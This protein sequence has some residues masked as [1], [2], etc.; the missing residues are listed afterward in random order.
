MKCRTALRVRSVVE[1]GL[2]TW[3]NPD[4]RAW[5][6]IRCTDDRVPGRDGASTVAASSY[7]SRPYS[8][9][10]RARLTCDSVPAGPR[11]LRPWLEDDVLRDEHVE[12]VA[13]PDLERGLDLEVAAGEFGSERRE[14]LPELGCRDLPR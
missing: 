3:L 6:S 13:R 7:S 4:L 2:P 9:G 8:S 12:A 5:S 1:T 11:S 10:A 14:L